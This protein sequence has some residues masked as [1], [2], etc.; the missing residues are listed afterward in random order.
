MSEIDFPTNDSVCG[1]HKSPSNAYKSKVDYH[2]K[3][4]VGEKNAKVKGGGSSDPKK[5]K[6][7]GGSL[8]GPK[9]KKV[10]GAEG[11]GPQTKKK[12]GG[13]PPQTKKKKKKEVREAE[14]GGQ[15]KK[16]TRWGGPKRK[17]VREAEGGVLRPKRKKRVRGGP[18]KTKK[19]ERDKVG[20]GG[21]VDDGGDGKQ[22]QNR[23]KARV[24]IK[25]GPWWK[26]GQRKPKPKQPGLYLSGRASGS[27]CGMGA[28]RALSSQPA[29]AT[30]PGGG[31]GTVTRWCPRHG[32]P[33]CAASSPTG[34][35]RGCRPPAADPVR[36]AAQGGLCGHLREGGWEGSLRDSPGACLRGRLAGESE[37]PTWDRP[38]ALVTGD[39]PG[40]F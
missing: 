7:R 18:P 20:G 21:A 37:A 14:G 35:P 30:R 9:R 22:R 6:V 38:S 11:G 32:D 31:H 34:H 5:T 26:G 2:A 10:R 12:G 36:T 29:T 39:R 23:E 8:M 1:F 13:G 19:K 27:P 15:T 40:A 17:K 25:R 33:V 3:K 28:P 24:Q 4:G 16:K